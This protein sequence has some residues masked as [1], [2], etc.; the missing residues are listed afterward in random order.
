MAGSLVVCLRDNLMLHISSEKT[1]R[2]KEKN[3]FEF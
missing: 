2:E 1:D 3:G